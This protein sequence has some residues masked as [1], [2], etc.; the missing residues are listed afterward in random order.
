MTYIKLNDLTRARL[1]FDDMRT[2]FG[3]TAR[4]NI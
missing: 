1:V 4:L 2:A 3:D